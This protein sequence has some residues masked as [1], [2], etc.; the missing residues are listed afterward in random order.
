MIMTRFKT[1]VTLTS[2]HLGSNVYLPV[3]SCSS[4]PSIVFPSLITLFSLS[5]FPSPL[6]SNVSESQ[7]S[8]LLYFVTFFTFTTYL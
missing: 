4:L 1:T 8:H 7:L 5:A 2:A 6:L 3:F